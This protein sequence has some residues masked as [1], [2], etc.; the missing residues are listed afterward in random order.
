LLHK[1]PGSLNPAIGAYFGTVSY[2]VHQLT[3]S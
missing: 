3:N 2:L 1:V